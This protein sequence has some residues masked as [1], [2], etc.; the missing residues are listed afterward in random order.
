M[1]HFYA[2]IQGD[3]GTATRTGTKNSGINGH[4]RGWGSGINI[5]AIY[6]SETNKDIFLISITGGSN[7]P[8]IKERIF[9]LTENKII[10]NN[11]DIQMLNELSEKR[12]SDKK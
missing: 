6:N 1:A 4:I 11:P 10:F 8:T 5:R 9:T 12:K 2:D 7:N 3:R